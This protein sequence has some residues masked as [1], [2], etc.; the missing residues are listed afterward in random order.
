MH[1][2]HRLSK[3]QKVKV[4][5]KVFSSKWNRFRLS[6]EKPHLTG[7]WMQ[8]TGFIIS[9]WSPGHQILTLKVKII[10][11]RLHCKTVLLPLYF[12]QKNDQAQRF[13]QSLHSFSFHKKFQ[14]IDI[15]DRLCKQWRFLQ[16]ETKE[17]TGNLE[18]GAKS[19]TKF[20]SFKYFVPT[21][22]NLKWNFWVPAKSI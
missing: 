19:A 8:W 5:Q 15:F 3:R 13:T 6:H 1:F 22:L 7:T 10:G 21:I 11:L 14:G 2:F 17:K 9:A 4:T 12:G 16:H 20:L 18:N